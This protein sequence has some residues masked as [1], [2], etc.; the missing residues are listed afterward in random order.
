[1]AIEIIQKSKTKIPLWGKIFF[2][3]SLVLALAAAGAYFY[4]NYSSQKTL[5]Q[6]AETQG[7]IKSLVDANRD[8]ENRVLTYQKKINDFGILLSAHQDTLNVF[9]F[10]EEKTHPEIQLTGFDF[11]ASKM[12]LA[13]KGEAKSFVALGQQILILK[14]ENILKNITLSEIK[15][16][17]GGKVSFSLQLV[18]DSQIVKQ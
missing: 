3:V 2:G 11:D 8:M 9:S 16:G 13:L 10:L 17:E 7:K 5:Q 6:I 18:F 4:M 1:M 15:L 12:S 14:G